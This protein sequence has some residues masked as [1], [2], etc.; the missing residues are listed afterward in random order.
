MLFL[1]EVAAGMYHPPHTASAILVLLCF[2]AVLLGA[3]HLHGHL[4]VRRH[5]EHGT[6][7]AHPPIRLAAFGALMIPRSI[8]VNFNCSF[9]LD[10]L[11]LRTVIN[12]SFY[13]NF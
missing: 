7:D 6:D 1:L 9:C 8:Y 2:Q 4:V 5:M 10:I 12:C 3:I 11:I 13:L